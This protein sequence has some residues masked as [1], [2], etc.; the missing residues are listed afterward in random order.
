MVDGFNILLSAIGIRLL[1]S[2][3]FTVG[4][5]VRGIR[6]L[7]WWHVRRRVR[8][9]SR[10]I[11]A[12]WVLRCSS[13]TRPS[14]PSQAPL[15]GVARREAE[16][17]HPHAPAAILP[18]VERRHRSTDRPLPG[19]IGPGPVSKHRP[20]MADQR[21]SLPKLPVRQPTAAEPRRGARPQLPWSRVS[22]RRHGRQRDDWRFGYGYAYNG[23]RMLRPWRL[24]DE[25]GGVWR[26]GLDGEGFCCVRGERD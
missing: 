9:R 24:I 26:K 10:P 5:T 1:D 6:D 19:H 20:V 11:D 23:R 4:L 12:S 14:L 13:G 17:G 7:R 8:R 21:A 22:G 18:R 16:P 3:L 15:N 2:V 25:G